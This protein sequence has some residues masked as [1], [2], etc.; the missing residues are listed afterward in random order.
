MWVCIEERAG[1]EGKG[2][3]MMIADETCSH[4]LEER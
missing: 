2:T 4:S 3:A 1:V